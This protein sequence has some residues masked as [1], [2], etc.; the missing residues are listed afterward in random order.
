[1]AGINQT[2]QLLD[3]LKVLA[4]AGKDVAKD[5]KISI[6]DLNV[7]F[8]V[9]KDLNKLIEAVKGVNEL[10]SEFKDLDGAEVMQLGQKVYDIVIELK[11]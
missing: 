5:G 4:V 1:M 7:L 9:F 11:K 8:G 6:E 10:P 2:L 3:G